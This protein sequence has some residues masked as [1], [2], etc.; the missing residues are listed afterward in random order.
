VPTSL[1]CGG[2]PY[3]RVAVFAVLTCLLVVAIGATDASAAKRSARYSASTDSVEAQV[4]RL[5][6]GLRAQQGLRTLRNDD[7]LDDAA[8]SHSR[9]MVT[10]GQF[11]HES[12]NGVPCDVR[13][14][15]F[16]KAR[17]VGETI[18]WL[19]GTP[20]SEQAQRTVE[21]WMNS[22]PHR[23]T[24]M[25][26]GFRRIGVSRKGGRMFGRQGV[27]FTADLAG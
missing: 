5:L 18:S 25:T 17:M 23:Q 14:R 12:A 9:G 10:S 16:V 19:A 11:S 20:A 15:R 21:L 8:A 1:A 4:I 26:A 27:A 22:P 3:V 2:P 13:I 7:G 6:N 24:L